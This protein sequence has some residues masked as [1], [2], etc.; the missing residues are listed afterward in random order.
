MD[1]FKSR[2]FLVIAFAGALAACQ[3]PGTQA[4]DQA[5]QAPSPAQTSDAAQ[6]EGASP[7]QSSAAP[8]SV[9]RPRAAV[10]A[11]KH[12]IAAANPHAAR[13]GLSVLRAGGSAVDAAIAAQLVLNV[14][15]PQ[16]SGIG[17]G[18]FL[19]HFSA[20]SGAIDAFDG[21]ET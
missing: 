12:M 7:V 15:E 18:G 8:A 6:P 21:R 11:S 4:P 9:A 20:A 19:M 1:V 14:V 17:G 2:A 5:Q 3:T 10:R 16:S 13:A